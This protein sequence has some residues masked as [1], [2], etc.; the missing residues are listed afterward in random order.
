MQMT[1]SAARADQ[2]ASPAFSVVLAASRQSNVI[3]GLRQYRSALDARGQKYE[4]LCVIESK[5][6]PQLEELK[7][8]QQDWP[9][10]E[11]FPRQPWGG[12][13]VE[14]ATAYGR[15]KSDLVLTLPSFVEIPP[16][17]ISKLFD[18]IGEA[19]M[20]VVNREFQPISGSRQMLLKR[21]FRS[22][23]GFT[24]S[25]VFSRVRLSRRSVLDE[26]GRF[27]VRQHFIPVIAANRGYVV[28]EA[29][30]A[31]SPTEQGA[32]AF[33][34]RPVGHASALFD[35]I[36]LF[37]VLKFLRRPLRFFGAIG[38]P[39]FLAG[40]ILTLA[41]VFGRLF[42]DMPLADRPALVFGVLLIVFGIQILAI[43]LVGE[44]IIFANSRRMK[45]YKVA[46]IIHRDPEAT[47]ARETPHNDP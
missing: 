35:A 25:D 34:F 38:L 31:K 9:E 2:I 44:I 27:G 4:V 6:H 21:I 36:A 7:T 5:D 43:G 42:F 39:T 40:V 24:V 22:L 26:V 30:V 28:V 47:E 32:A 18:K 12:E 10:L 20:V 17:E 45:Q 13:D 41:L 15:T 29:P 8:L 37:V 11:L 16:E 1:A 14:L 33:S 19:D 3:E 23:F 46:S